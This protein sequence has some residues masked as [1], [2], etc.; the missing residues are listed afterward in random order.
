MP[1][2]SLSSASGWKENTTAQQANSSE[3]LPP[4]QTTQ[5]FADRASERVF[6]RLD[7]DRLFVAV[8]PAMR[9]VRRQIEQLAAIEA[10]VLLFGESGTGKEA[11]ARLV[12][13]LSNRSPHRFMKVNCAASSA[14]LLESELFGHEAGAFSGARMARSGKLEAVDKGTLLLDDI[15]G[16][17]RAAQAMLLHFLQDGEFSHLG[18]TS[19][20]RADVRVLAAADGDL[21]RALREGTLRPD[22]YYRLNVFSIHL[23]PLRERREDLPY[24]LNHFMAV[25][26]EAYGRPRLPITRRILDVCSRYGWPGNLRELENFIKRYLVLNDEKPALDQIDI[27][28]LEPEAPA[29]SARENA[30]SPEPPPRANAAEGTC[31]LKSVVRGLK[32]DAER[33]AIVAALERTGGNKQEA[34]GL[35][36]ISLRALHYKV[37]AYHIESMHAR[38]QAAA[39]SGDPVALPRAV[40]DNVPYE[41][42]RS[43]G[44]KLISMHR[45]P[46]GVR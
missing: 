36:R 10:P 2:L 18:S 9:D 29:S 28:V 33:A 32:Q 25:W 38:T 14:E 40:G 5:E 11:A 45:A 35:L 41:R 21:R 37:R 46:S 30:A 44:G 42:P 31:D 3:N 19:T 6:D 43:S 24:L 13:K 23:P 22:L 26:A 12:H 27:A 34:A 16:M 20:M 4:A 39:P 1:N 17:P 8:S 15:G 7:S